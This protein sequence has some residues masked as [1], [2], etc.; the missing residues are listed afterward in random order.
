MVKEGFDVKAQVG[1]P[2]IYEEYVHR[3]GRTGRAFETGVAITFVTEADVYHIGRIEA[4]I[5]DKI[6]VAKLP[7]EIIVEET[8]FEESQA[9]ARE[10]DKQKRREDPDFKGAFHDRK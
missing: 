4:M 5:N 8:P 3:I 9:L 10:L 6:K 1:V 7:Q 2:M